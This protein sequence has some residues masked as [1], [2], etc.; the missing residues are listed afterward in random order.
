[1]QGILKNLMHSPVQVIAKPAATA[2]MRRRAKMEV[3]QFFFDESAMD[4]N[5]QVIKT[6]V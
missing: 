1:M 4:T 6:S 3:K 5:T 2:Q